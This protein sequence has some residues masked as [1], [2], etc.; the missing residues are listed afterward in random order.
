MT[1]S[2]ATSASSSQVV[3]SAADPR[4]LQQFLVRPDDACVADDVRDPILVPVE[5]SFLEEEHAL[6]GIL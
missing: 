6:S 5:L 1:A 2:P 3:G 4:L